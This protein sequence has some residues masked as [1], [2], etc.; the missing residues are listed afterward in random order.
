MKRHWFR[1][2]SFKFFSLFILIT[3]V[4]TIHSC[5]KDLKNIPE[6]DD[7][8]DVVAKAKAWYESAYPINQNVTGGSI[9]TQSVSGQRDLSQWIKPDWKKNVT[10]NRL[11]KGVIEMPIAAGSNFQSTVRIGNRLINKAYSRSY[12][13]LLND[14]KQYKAYIMMIVAD[15]DYVKNDFTK[16]ARNSYRKHE[17]DFSG[18]LMYFTPKGDYLAG[19]RYK[20]GKLVVRSGSDSPTNEKKTQNVKTNGLIPDKMVQ[21]CTDWYIAYYDSEGVLIYAVYIGTTCDTYDDGQPDDSPGGGDPPPPPKCP[22]VES[23]VNNHLLI[24]FIPPPDDPGDGG[25][26]PPPTD[27]PCKPD[28]P[29]PD[30]TKTDTVPPNDPCAQKSKINTTSQNATIKTQNTILA[31]YANTSSLEHGYAQNLKSMTGS[32]YFDSPLITA[33]AAT[34]D[35]LNTTFSWDSTNGF[36]IGFSHDHPNG[37]APSPQDIFSMVINSQSQK[38][39]SAGTTAVSF[40]K[41]NASVTVVTSDNNYVVTV[42]NWTALQT[43]Y[44]EYLQNKA[45]FD[46]EITDNTALFS[47]YEAALL[48]KFGNSINLYSDYSSSQSKTFYPLTITTGTDHD[49][50]EVPCP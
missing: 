3:A 31:N 44:N 39:T 26:V 37:T 32:T 29:K 17:P 45:A 4:I 8:S 19:Y 20:G 11:G 28:P 13:L 22:P 49:I 40:Y 36:T 12:F 43:L 16:L 25:Y 9:L 47:S 46:K 48:S 2:N 23:S 24:N 5:K 10:Y 15:S 42:R 14:G 33:N 35:I 38:L 1:S 6:T 50:S 21:E 41:S 18:Y 7:V 30:T 34:P 27:D